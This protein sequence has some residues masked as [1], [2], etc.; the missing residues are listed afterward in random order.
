MRPTCSRPDCAERGAAR[1][2]IDPSARL[3]VI[4]RHVDQPGA[5]ILCKE[6]A[7]RVT[8][9]KGWTLDDRREDNPRLFGVGR[10]SEPKT[11]RER[12]RRLPE[13]IAAA[14]AQLPLENA[15]PYD[16]PKAYE[17]AREQGRAKATG[18]ETP[19][20]DGVEHV[21]VTERALARAK[22]REQ[23]GIDSRLYAKGSPPG[24]LLA[25]AFDATRSRVRNNVGLSSLIPPGD[26]PLVA[27]AGA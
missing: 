11:P 21:S 13:T 15:T 12:L 22:A 19:V 4:D 3:I 20:V 24:P 1:A 18:S 16:M 8:V 26:E 14:V 9:P 10:F 5:A 25:R 2:L 7:D 17:T 27:G 23:E 6:H